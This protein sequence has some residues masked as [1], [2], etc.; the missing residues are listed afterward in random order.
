[1]PMRTAMLSIV[2]FICI[3]SMLEARDVGAQDRPGGRKAEVIRLPDS[4]TVVRTWSDGASANYAISVNGEPFVQVMDSSFDILLRFAEFDPAMGEPEVPVHLRSPSREGDE[5]PRAYIVQFVTQPLEEYVVGIRDAGGVARVFLANHAFLVHMTRP[6]QEA[7]ANLPYVRWVGEY[8]AA[9]KLEERLVAALA[10]SEGELPPARYNIQVFE[11]GLAHKQ[12][13]AAEVAAVGGEVTA[14]IP[15]GFLLEAVLDGQQLLHIARMHEVLFIDRWSPPENDMNVARDI[16]GGN[17]I[18]TVEGFSGE[19]VRAEVMDDGLQNTHVDFQANPPIMHGSFSF[20]TSHG[21]ST[22]G[23][24]FGTGSGNS[25]ARGMAPDAQGI[26]ADYGS[27]TNRYTHTAQLVQSPYFAVY[28]SNSWG[29]ARTT[30]YTSISHQMDDI[31]FINDIV[32][33]Q[34]QSNAGNQD[35][36]PQAWAKNIVS[37]GGVRHQNTLSKTDDNWG[38]GG[39]TGPAADGRIKPDLTHFYDSI[40]TTTGGSNTAY[41][42]GFGGTSGATPITAGHFAIFF[43]MW[44]NGIFANEVDGNAT[45]FENRPHMATAKAM[46]INSASPYNWT[47]GGANGDLTRFRQGWGMADLQKMHANRDKMFIIDETQPLNNLETA[48]QQLTVAANTPELRVTLVY[49]DLPGT[50]SSTQHRINDLSLKVTAPGGAVYWGNNGLTAGIWSVAG[51]AADTKNTVENVFIQ[52]P[53]SGTWTVQVIASQVVQDSHLETGELDA[54]FALVA[55]GV[56]PPGG[57][58]ALA[59]ATVVFGTHLSGGLAQLASSDDDWFRARSAFGFTASQPNVVDTEIGFTAPTTSPTTLDILAEARINQ[60]GGTARMRIRNWSTG[61]L[62]LLG[63]YPIDT[64]ETI[65]SFLGVSAADRVRQS[66]RRVELSFRQSTVVTFS[67]QGF[68]TSIDHVQVTA[69]AQ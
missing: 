24:N 45:V 53:A 51:G 18:E 67:A 10:D 2:T 30:Q 65:Q 52:N 17:F 61:T 33:C 47:Q 69:N 3:T 6:A 7:V 39:S 54:D 31:L 34:S 60:T 63:Q 56:V 57:A 37:V 40:L 68:V 12:A 27:L 14:M 1:M 25:S 59:D 49:T 9:Y 5:E 16:G 8:H 13:V 42:S 55:S 28:Q 22:Y 20:G 46:M 19:G 38:G 29:D 66:D 48:T 23:I 32:I 64:A 44:H 50:T 4:R 43:Q 21:S 58:A 26:F 35:S 41:T 11:R 62:S 36:R 15:D